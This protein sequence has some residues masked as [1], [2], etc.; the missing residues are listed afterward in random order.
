MHAD[1]RFYELVFR[2]FFAKNV[3]AQRQILGFLPK[4]LWQKFPSLALSLSRCLLF[5]RGK[6]E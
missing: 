5:L 3:G 4:Q 1:L 2:N 6:Q